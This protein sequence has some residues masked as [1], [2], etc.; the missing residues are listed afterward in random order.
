MQQLGERLIPVHANDSLKRYLQFDNDK[1][2]QHGE[3]DAKLILNYLEYGFVVDMVKLEK[4]HDNFGLD[5]FSTDNFPYGG[6]ERF[7]K[8][9]IAF[10]LMPAEC[11]DGFTT[12]GFKWISN[13]E[14]D[15]ID[16]TGKKTL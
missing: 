7:F 11:Y 9:L 10:D 5:E 4:Q 13:F 15:T 6:T 12:Y 2:K 16:L 1:L 14:Y 3:L 8:V